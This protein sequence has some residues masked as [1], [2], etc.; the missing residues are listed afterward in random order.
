M[1][2]SPRHAATHPLFASARI[3]ARVMEDLAACLE[4]GIS[5]VEA[6]ELVPRL[7]AR[8]GGEQ[9]VSPLIL[10]GARTA[11]AADQPSALSRLRRNDLILLDVVGGAKG[12]GADFARMFTWGTPEARLQ[13]LHTELKH[14]LLETLGQ[15]AVGVPLAQVYHFAV[16]RLER[17]FG[18]PYEYDRIGHGID[19]LDGRSLVVGRDSKEVFQPGMACAIEPGLYDRVQGIGLRLESNIVVDARGEVFL[20]PEP[21]LELRDLSLPRTHLGPAE[22]APTWEKALDAEHSIDGPTAPLGRRSFERALP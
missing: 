14:I 7:F 4:P 21:P 20:A 1:T 9:I 5:E 19:G 13:E 17:S 16:A 15:V 10:F 11:T 12:V 22:E 8:H 6:A 18:I 3:A 2:G